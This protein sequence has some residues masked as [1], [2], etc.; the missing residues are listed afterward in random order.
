MGP[1]SRPHPR[2]VEPA[3]RRA[4]SHS[5]RTVVHGARRGF[6]IL[7]SACPSSQRW[8]RLGHRWRRLR[9]LA[10]FA[11][12][13]PRLHVHPI[14][15]L[16][17]SSRRPRVAM[18]SAPRLSDWPGAVLTAL[19]LPEN[20]PGGAERRLANPGAGPRLLQFPAGTLKS[21]FCASVPGVGMQTR[22]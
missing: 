10:G 8:R 15:L 9:V 4:Q 6:G 22:T 1:G 11:S 13:Q 18:A 19:G 3:E 2:R 17:L 7:P 21:A 5:R 16:S 12:S 20:E 14:T